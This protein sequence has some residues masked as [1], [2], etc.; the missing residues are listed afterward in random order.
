MV[1]PPADRGRDGGHA[2]LDAAVI[3]IDNGLHRKLSEV[4]AR[5]EPKT[6]DP[7]DGS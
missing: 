4:Y 5:A 1:V 2:A 6:V 3:T 7:F